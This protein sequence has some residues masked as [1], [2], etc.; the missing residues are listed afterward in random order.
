MCLGGTWCSSGTR[1]AVRRAVVRLREAGTGVGPDQGRASPPPALHAL[2]RETGYMGRAYGGPVAGHGVT[3]PLRHAAQDTTGF[4]IP[5]CGSAAPSK[6][7]AS[8]LERPPHAAETLSIP[9]RCRKPFGKRRN[10]F[11]FLADNCAEMKSDEGAELFLGRKYAGNSINFRVNAFY[12]YQ[13]G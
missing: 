6:V 11:V 3:H 5:Q 13:S 4:A 9:K 2:F 8:L 7:F 10:A 12:A 1:P